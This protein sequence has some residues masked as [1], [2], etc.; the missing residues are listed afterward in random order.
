MAGDIFSNLFFEHR[1]AVLTIMLLNLLA[2]TG[3]LE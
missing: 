3:G 1:M 2:L